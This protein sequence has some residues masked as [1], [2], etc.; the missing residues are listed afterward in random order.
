MEKSLA[1]GLTLD[2]NP[3]SST[4]KDGSSII[5]SAPKDPPSYMYVLYGDIFYLIVAL[6]NFTNLLI[7]TPPDIFDEFDD[8]VGGGV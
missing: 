4:E 3:V 7:R 1:S 6:P 2:V 8:I 5:N